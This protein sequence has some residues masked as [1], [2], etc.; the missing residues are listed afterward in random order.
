MSIFTFA[1][2]A[3]VKKLDLNTYQL[4]CICTTC[5]RRGKLWFFRD[6]KMSSH[7]CPNCRKKTLKTPEWLNRYKQTSVFLNKSFK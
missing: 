4:D 6:Y 3:T 7:N 2:F 5:K 1:R